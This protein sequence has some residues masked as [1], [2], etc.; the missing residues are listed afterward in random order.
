MSPVVLEGTRGGEKKELN[1]PALKSMGGEKIKSEEEFAI[2]T[3]LAMLNNCI[4]HKVKRNNVLLKGKPFQIAERE[5]VGG[6]KYTTIRIADD[7]SGEEYR[8]L[9]KA[10]NPDY[11]GKSM[12]EILVEEGLKSLLQ[13]KEWVGGKGSESLGK[14][15]VT[16]KSLKKVVKFFSRRFGIGYRK[17]KRE[18]LN[19]LRE[20]IN[21]TKHLL[22]E[23]ESKLNDKEKVK[24][25]VKALETLQNTLHETLPPESYW[26]NSMKMLSSPRRMLQSLYA[27]C[28]QKSSFAYAILNCIKP[29]NSRLIVNMAYVIEDNVGREGDHVC[30]LACLHDGSDYLFD[31]TIPGIGGHIPEKILKKNSVPQPEKGSPVTITLEQGMKKVG[32]INVTRFHRKIRIMRAEELISS[33]QYLRLG[34]VYYNREEYEKAIMAYQKALSIHPEFLDAYFNLGE[35]YAHLGNVKEAKEMYKKFLKY[36][37]QNL[38]SPHQIAARDF[39]EAHE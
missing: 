14:E 9:T 6:L 19:K 26:G 30:L 18:S 32:G 33:V 21:L 29:R 34:N 36:S 38:S 28:D 24:L 11:E 5:S 7:L 37:P 23:A 20:S 15:N 31:A 39:V 8:E 35:T 12:E 4:L 2:I 25:Q 16:N 22:R 1:L 13:I 27:L 17:S 3:H 10:I